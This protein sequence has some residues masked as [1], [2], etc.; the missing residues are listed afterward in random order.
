MVGA[1]KVSL[2]SYDVDTGPKKKITS[3]GDIGVGNEDAL[4]FN[5]CLFSSFPSSSNSSYSK[6][7]FEFIE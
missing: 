2:T 5:H 6:V 3:V 7:F 1:E 4:G